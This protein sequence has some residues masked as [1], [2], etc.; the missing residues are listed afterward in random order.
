MEVFKH[1]DLR[2]QA[3][4]KKMGVYLYYDIRH[5]RMLGWSVNGSNLSGQADSRQR[6]TTRLAGETGHDVATFCDM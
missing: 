1:E 3:L 2:A 4:T 6:I 5:S